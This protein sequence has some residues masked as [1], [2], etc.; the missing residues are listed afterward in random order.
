MRKTLILAPLLLVATPAL[1]QSAPPPAG[2]RIPEVLTD[3]ATADQV[4][5]A[6]QALSDALL[7][8]PVGQVQA[9]L[10]G[11]RATAADRRTTVRDL[12]RRDDPD[13][14]RKLQR[15]IAQ[16]GPKIRDSMKAVADALPSV[17]QSLDQAQK[18]IERAA[19]NMPDP[20]YPRR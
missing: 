4:A 17:M 11:R 3:P 10:E 14:D 15:Q 6:A 1:A 12:A 20:T 19:A 18:A 8:L 16:A 13:F 9:A 5:S 7:N 2:V